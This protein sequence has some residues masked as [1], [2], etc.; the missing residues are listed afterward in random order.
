MAW[1]SLVLVVLAGC[2]I[3][4]DSTTGPLSG[5]DAG[6]EAGPLTDAIDNWDASPG[7]QQPAP[8]LYLIDTH[9]YSSAGTLEA[10]WCSAGLSGPVTA[11]LLVD[12][13]LTVRAQHTVPIA[14][15]RVVFMIF[16]S[17]CTCFTRLEANGITI[18]GP[19]TMFTG[20]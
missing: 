5:G 8:F 1:R 9:E 19:P 2:R 14:D 3:G 16:G 18:D 15:Q 17:G 7:C 12:Q 13:S 10:T 6:L 11:T 20:D 4:F